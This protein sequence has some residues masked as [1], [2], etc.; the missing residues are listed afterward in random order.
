MRAR[1]LHPAQVFSRTARS[2]GAAALVLA[3][4]A[5]CSGNKAS[6]SAGAAAPAAGTEEAE[7]LPELTPA[8][9]PENIVGL[10]TLRTPAHTLDTAMAWTG[11]GLDFRMFLASGPGAALL[12]VLDLE[13]PVD[14]VMT[15]DPKVKTRPRA[16][17][18]AS[19]GLT[20][21]KAALE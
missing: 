20:S 9:P 16:L 15:L 21:E 2:C 8:P 4:F 14:A 6:D 5:G 19:I 17:F 11:L 7:P 10:A 12:P 13:A 1:P 3:S 18:A